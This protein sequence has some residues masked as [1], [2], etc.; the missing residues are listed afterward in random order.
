[1]KKAERNPVDKTLRAL[2]WLVES[3]APQVGVR[4]IATAMNIAPSSA[5]R[6]LLALTEAGYIRQDRKTQRYALCT[7]FFRLSQIA[8]EKAPVQQAAMGAMQRLVDDFAESTL[9]CIYD[10]RRQEAIFAVAVEAARSTGRLVQMNKWR[11][12]RSGASALAILAWLK[13]TEVQAIMRRENDDRCKNNDGVTELGRLRSELAVVRGNGYA[14]A[15]C[16]SAAGGVCLAAP[17]FGN[18]G[19][20]LGTIGVTVPQ[21]RVKKERMDQV[22]NAMCYCANDVSKK[23][24]KSA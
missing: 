19:R 24:Y 5:H 13:E 22:I 14:S 11:P 9:L 4:Q 21:E 6:I 12:I 20:V 10:E 1:M 15:P 18:R 3:S 17:I 8:I 2:S 7:E 23:M 16:R